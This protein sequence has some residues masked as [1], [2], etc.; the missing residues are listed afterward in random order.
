MPYDSAM[1]ALQDCTSAAFAGVEVATDALTQTAAQHTLA[2]INP[3]QFTATD[4]RGVYG[5]VVKADV[6]AGLDHVVEG[7]R[8]V[9]GRG[10]LGAG[11]VSAG[12]ISANFALFVKVAV[13]AKLR[14]KRVG[15]VRA[16]VMGKAVRRASSQDSVNRFV[17]N[18]AG[19]VEAAL[20][21][22]YAVLTAEWRPVAWVEATGRENY[23]HASEELAEE[24]DVRK[25]DKVYYL[26]YDVGDVAYGDVKISGVVVLVF[27]GGEKTARVEALAKSVVGLLARFEEVKWGG[28]RWVRLATASISKPSGV[29]RYIAHI[30]PRVAG[31]E[32]EARVGRVFSLDS[33]A[34]LLLTDAAGGIAL[35]TPDPLLLKCFS[36][37]FER[38]RLEMTDVVH[39]EAGLTLQFKAI[40]LDDKPFRELLGDIA[41]RYSVRLR[42]LL[43]KAKGMAVDAIAKL[44]KDIDRVVEEAARVGREEGV[45][46]SRRALVEGLRRLFE[47]KEREAFNAGRRGEALAVAVAGRLLLKAVESPMGWLSLLVGDGVVDMARKR[48]GFSAKPAEVA[49][50]VLRL[51]AVWA[52]AYGAKVKVRGNMAE[53]TNVSDVEEVL[54]AVLVGKALEFASSLVKSWNGLAGSH[55]PKLV[56]LLTLAQLLGVV[57]GKWAVELWLAHRA[58]V[59]STP[60]AMAELFKRVVRVE[61]VK[62]ME[63]S[64]E[65]YF[66]LWDA[67]RG[68]SRAIEFRLKTDL[69][70]FRLYCDSYSEMA[71]RGAL[72]AFARELGAELK[73][74]KNALRLSA[75]VGWPLFL[76]LWERYK[77]AL[78]VEEDGREVLRIEVLEVRPDGSAR[79][80]L[81]YYKWREMRPDSPYVNFE[82]KLYQNRGSRIGFKG[83]VYANDAEGISRKH[84]VEVAELLKHRGIEGVSV[85]SMGKVLQLTGV[86]RDYIFS[87]LG[88]VPELPEGELV[89][90]EYLDGFRF[91]IGDY[92]VGF[93][94]RHGRGGREFYAVL[95]LSSSYEAIRLA[96]SLKLVSVDTRAVGDVVRLDSDAFF[97]LLAATGAVP[98]GLTPLYRSDDFHVYAS[99]EEGRMRFYFAVKHEG[100]WRVAEGLYDERTRSVQL[101]RA[102]HEVLETV[103]GAVARTLERLGYPAE[104][105]VPK[106]KGSE[107][108]N[109]KVYYLKLFNHHLVPLLRHAAEGVTAEPAEVRL[110]G[111]RIAV[112]V[113]YIEV[114]VEFRLLK[115]KEAVCLLATDVRQILALYKALKALGI[116]VEITPKGVK[117]D[118]EAMWSLVATAVENAA[119][120]GALRVQEGWW[121]TEVIPGV[122][123]LKVYSVGGAHM[124]AFRV[125]GL[126]YYFAVKTGQGWK[127]S[128]GKYDGNQVRLLGDAIVAI[129]GAINAIYCEMG[130]DKEIEARRDKDG[131]PY[132]RLSNVDLELLGLCR[133]S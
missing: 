78:L 40:T 104:V 123:L 67:L 108:E 8:A 94:K 81:W 62:W 28:E 38:V 119:E 68:A 114:A 120:K 131:I 30:E 6:D 64:V 98:P 12:Y 121:Q 34:G 53:Y 66:K 82:I 99:V 42:D 21:L 102:E 33:L 32:S 117:V 86:F 37:H 80:R 83:Y 74:N 84:L 96:S 17:E 118:G 35:R 132:I 65:V 101:W 95:K 112:R 61:K 54:R 103:R 91:K 133:P 79:L 125:G 77:T 13:Q 24:L 93:G 39:T 45:G 7:L 90:V 107:E 41:E 15:I 87:K 106:G 129:A 57:E 49:E 72:E 27:L 16:G 60:L 14:T 109:V 50:A 22:A 105:G 111:R 10:S 51:L 56:S 73:W 124:Y 25:K 55:A 85:K 126:H 23:A 3:P 59:A 48:L 52:G 63:R 36:M 46:A 116:P 130:V 43:D 18:T 122:E 75:E 47:G 44:S 100:V 29:Q 88:L 128:G 89:V 58:A 26:H 113:G 9:E 20:G 5:F 19:A 69:N 76:K 115:G 71:S 31:L 92:E 70:V 97:G 2:T 110:E 1:L 127:A 4:A 11:W